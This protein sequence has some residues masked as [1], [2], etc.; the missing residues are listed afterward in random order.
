MGWGAMADR[1]DAEDLA[2]DSALTARPL[3]LPAPLNRPPTLQAETYPAKDRL[4]G[5]VIG[6]LDFDG[7]TWLGP[8]LHDALDLSLSGLDLDLGGIRFCDCSG[9]DVLLRLRRHAL[10]D[11]RT[12]IIRQSSPAVTRVLALT[13]ALPLFTSTSLP[14]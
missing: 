11:R 5:V 13:A 12:V 7:A 3:T 6:E 8:V 9:L 1:A 14:P 4:L 2:P 10:R